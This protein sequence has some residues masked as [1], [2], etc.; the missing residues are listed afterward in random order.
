[1]AAVSGAG[2]LAKGFF[3]VG[4][5]KNKHIEGGRHGAGREKTN[6]PSI[7]FDHAGGAAGLRGRRLVLRHAGAPGRQSDLLVN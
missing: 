6:T 2:A 3:E 1:M 5:L 4:D 7:R